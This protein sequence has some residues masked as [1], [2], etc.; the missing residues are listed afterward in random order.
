MDRLRIETSTTTIIPEGY[1]SSLHEMLKSQ[2]QVASPVDKKRGDV[3]MQDTVQSRYHET[4]M[5]INSIRWDCPHRER[6]SSTMLTTDLTFSLHQRSYKGS[7]RSPASSVAAD[8]RSHF[9]PL[10]DT[11]QD[12]CGPKI[13]A[14]TI[15]LFL[16]LII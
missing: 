7:K 11:S 4:Y 13:R 16:S 3:S 2:E 15:A 9:S 12:M 5:V 8:S 1:F 14:S 10:S 6:T